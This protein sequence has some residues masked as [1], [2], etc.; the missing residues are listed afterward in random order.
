[1]INII[2]LILSATTA[3]LIS[4]LKHIEDVA[5]DEV[6]ELTGRWC[7]HR[8]DVMDSLNYHA[9]WRN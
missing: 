3:W 7:H 8:V 1:M 9:G 6:A 2:R 5:A 4:A